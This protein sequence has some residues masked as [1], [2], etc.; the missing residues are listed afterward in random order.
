MNPEGVAVAVCGSSLVFDR[1]FEAD[2][3]VPSDKMD[4]GL[5]AGEDV[6]VFD[7]VG[8]ADGAVASDKREVG[9]CAGDDVTVDTLTGWPAI[10]LGSTITPGAAGADVADAMLPG[11]LLAA[12]SSWAFWASTIAADDEAADVEPMTGAEAVVAILA[13]WLVTPLPSPAC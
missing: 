4:V 7:R 13:D 9:L 12:P 1:V 10:W 8:K 5:C 2:G 6:L 3:G 11:C